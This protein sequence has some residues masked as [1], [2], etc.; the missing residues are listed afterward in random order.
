LQNSLR[1]GA[2]WDTSK[3]KCKGKGERPSVTWGSVISSAGDGEGTYLQV[4]ERAPT[5]PCQGAL[6]PMLIPMMVHLPL[7]QN[8]GR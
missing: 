5:T 7:R 1:T 4:M 3:G 2:Y 6:V 8:T